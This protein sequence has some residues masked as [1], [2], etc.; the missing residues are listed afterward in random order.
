MYVC[1]NHVKDALCICSVRSVVV[2]LLEWEIQHGY[3]DRACVTCVWQPL[4]GYLHTS[5]S[6]FVFPPSTSSKCYHVNTRNHTAYL[7]IEHVREVV[8][9]RM[10]ISSYIQCYRAKDW[11]LVITSRSLP[12]V[13]LAHLRQPWY[14]NNHGITQ[15]NPITGYSG[16]SHC[17]LIQSRRFIR[18]VPRLQTGRFEVW[19]RAQNPHFCDKFTFKC[20]FLQ[21]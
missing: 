20:S 1:L 17:N 9:A 14:H 6:D 15:S 10:R 8:T 16:N 2:A 5:P 12:K 11:I 13:Y 3:G 18:L 7:S 19:E 4:C 21:L